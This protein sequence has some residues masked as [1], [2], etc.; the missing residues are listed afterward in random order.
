MIR[1]TEQQ[2]AALRAVEA[3]GRASTRDLADD[4]GV[5]IQHANIVARA[6]MRVGLLMRDKGQHEGRYR[7]I[8]T[9]V[10]E[11]LAY[12]VQ[13]PKTKKRARN[14]RIRA[15]LRGAK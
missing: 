7:W 5:S 6:L 2:G 9:T 4:L 1:I 14:A 13:E 12:T 11:S 3:L 8:Y 15:A 10:N